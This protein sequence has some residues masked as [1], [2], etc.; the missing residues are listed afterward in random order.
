MIATDF[1]FP[2]SVTIC[3][4]RTGRTLPVPE[5]SRRRCRR[6]ETAVG[7]R[8][9]RTGRPAE[10]TGREMKVSWRRAARRIRT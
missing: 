1:A 7:G 2:T 6:P 9:G 8:L 10:T 3:A 4:F 5:P